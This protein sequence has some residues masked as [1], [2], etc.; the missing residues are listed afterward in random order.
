MWEFK[1]ILWC[2]QLNA[3]LYVLCRLSQ[4]PNKSAI[5]YNTQLAPFPR[6]QPTALKRTRYKVY[7][8]RSIS[9]SDTRYNNAGWG[10]RSR[11]GTYTTVCAQYICMLLLRGGGRRKTPLLRSFYCYIGFRDVATIIHP[12]QQFCI[13]DTRILFLD[14]LQIDCESC[15]II[16]RDYISQRT[17]LAISKKN[18]RAQTK[19]KKTK[20]SPEDCAIV[21]IGYEY[22]PQQNNFET[23]F[24][25]RCFSLFF[26]LYIYLILSPF[27]FLFF[28]RAQRESWVTFIVV[29]FRPM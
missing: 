12:A 8:L 20:F 9:I 14:I 13:Y 29:V 11:Q 15:Y 26:S 7:L 27:R 4:R 10:L 21:C 17:F 19:W 2:S 18:I 28:Q 22:M 6:L 23:L 3:Y 25:F 5:L 24:L 1:Y 16:Y